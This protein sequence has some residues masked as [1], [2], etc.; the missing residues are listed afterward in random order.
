[1]QREGSPLP[2]GCTWLSSESAYN[3]ALY[4]KHA[5]RVVL[6]AFTEED[7]V[8]PAVSFELDYRRHK[9]GR[10]WHI[11]VPEPELR[12][13][14]YYAY[15]VAGPPPAGRVEWHAFDAEKML[16]DPYADAVYFPPAFDREAAITRGSNAGRAPLGIMPPAIDADA[17][18]TARTSASRAPFHE[19]DAVIYELHVRNFTM[20]PSSGV[21]AGSRGTFAGIVEKIPYLVDLGVTVVELMPVF[22]YDPGAPDRWGYMPLSFFA[23]HDRYL[24]VPDPGAGHREFRDMV[25][26]LHHAGI[27]VVLDVVY[28]HTAE[29]G[30]A[31]PVY[32]YKGIDNSTYYIMTGDAGRPYADFAGTGNTMNC[33]NHAVRKMILDSMRHWVRLGVDGFRFDLAS[34]YARDSEGAFRYEEPP[35][36]GEISA[37]PEFA[38]V[39]LIAEPW[40]AGAYQLGRGFPGL[41]WQQWNGAFRDD[42]RRF[43]RGD[44]GSTPS[45][46]RRL[47]GSD[48][49]FPDD[50]THA[51]RPPQSVNYV[52]SH[53][54]PTL[55]DL[56]SFNHKRN[57]ANG[58]GNTDGPS[59][60]YGWNCGW[61]GDEHVPADV[62][63]LRRQQAKN[64]VALLF[65][66]NGTPMLRAGDEFLHTQRGNDN[67][68]NQD[69]ETTWLDWRRVDERVE[70]HRFVKLAIAFRKSHPSIARSRYWR[71][72]V[73]WYDLD[74]DHAHRPEA[75]RFAFCLYGHSEGDA[76]LYAMINASQEDATMTIRDGDAA[77]WRR[78]ID[79]A[80][81]S[82]QD[83]LAAGDEACV[84]SSEYQVGARSVVLFVRASKI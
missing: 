1:M 74:P 41:S 11:R 32:G 30:Q 37:D 53:D 64:F 54:G 18:A 7:L 14:R 9:S 36:I 70:M 13:A 39:R 16:L 75:S 21:S 83:F 44:P 22:Q 42:V 79:T 20:H 43:V 27:E 38:T 40:D 61:E 15:S 65:L 5:E 67:P 33:V 60:S 3:F 10:V 23:L 48:D 46:A 31:G 29:G 28:N 69:D 55:Y 6:L 78:V 80:R 49:L 52:T 17:A 76:D 57:W 62:V 81:P 73:R 2:L 8:N 63:C 4:S 59:Q 19:A 35:I 25:D 47:Y 72:D 56:V 26:A 50:R 77:E 71:E 34:I 45:M 84:E 66:S 82:P 12:G 51:Y 68:Y 24:S 58:Q